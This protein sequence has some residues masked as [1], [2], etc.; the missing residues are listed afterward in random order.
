M[1]HLAF[2]LTSRRCCHDTELMNL[3]HLFHHVPWCF[4]ITKSPSSH[5]K[6]LG[7]SIDH[8]RSVF[9]LWQGCDTDVI[10]SLKEEDKFKLKK[11]Q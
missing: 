5:C 7:K 11:E 8:D 2:A 9:H 1:H 3:D 10:V 6:C 4:N